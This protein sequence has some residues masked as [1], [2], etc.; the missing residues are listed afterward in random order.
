MILK[1]LPFLR[2]LSQFIVMCGG[3][4]TWMA[5]RKKSVSK[6]PAFIHVPCHQNTLPW[7]AVYRTWTILRLIIQIKG[8][9]NSSPSRRGWATSAI[10]YGSSTDSGAVQVLLVVLP[11]MI[12]V[13]WI[14]QE[15]DKLE[16]V[17]KGA[18]NRAS[19][20]ESGSVF[21]GE[22]FQSLLCPLL[23]RA[24]SWRHCRFHWTK[25]KELAQGLDWG[26]VPPC[27]VHQ[28]RHI[29]LI[30]LSSLFC[31]N[32]CFISFYLLGLTFGSFFYSRGTAQ[33]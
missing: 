3:H 2:P 6:E 15:M 22:P 30:F 28:T 24:W 17:G 29:Y 21:L 25:G 9:F 7:M 8:P 19:E 26:W 12:Y 11:L 4:T 23:P 33:N 13:R 14:W 5:K 1:P 31:R 16:R 27:T 10:N 18:W 20:C 32:I